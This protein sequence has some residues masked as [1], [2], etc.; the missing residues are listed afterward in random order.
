MNLKRLYE[1]LDTTTVMLRKG[2]EVTHKQDGEMAIVE[3]YDMPHESDAKK[4]LIKVDMFFLIIG[5]DKESA[6]TNKAELIEILN[7]YPEMDRLKG[8]PSYI[9]L[10][11]E[12]GDQGQA[13]RLFALGKVLGLWD[14]MTPATLKIYGVQAE[15]AAGQGL[16]YITGYKP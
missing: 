6:E 14:V 16:I 11:A 3:I 9:E 10:G 2:P 8:G 13:L 7:T 5:V 4:E 1:I 15:L 12:I